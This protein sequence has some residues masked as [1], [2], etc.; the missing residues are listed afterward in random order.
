MMETDQSQTE[1]YKA[2]KKRVKEIKGFYIHLLVY[3]MVNLF[4]IFGSSRDGS[5]WDRITDPSSFITAGFWGIGLFAHAAGV[6]GG[7]LLLGQ[8]WEEKKIAEYLE[9]EKREMKKWE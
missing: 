5:L 4:L 8:K 9:K 6:F 7:G 1:R 2:A 3:V